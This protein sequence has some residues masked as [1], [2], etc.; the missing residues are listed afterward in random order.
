MFSI[1]LLPL[2]AYLVCCFVATGTGALEGWGYSGRTY[3]AFTW[4]IHKLFMP[5]RVGFPLGL[6]LGA[7][8]ALTGASGWVLV[9]QVAIVLLAWVQAFTFFHQ[10]GYFTVR[11]AIDPAQ[12]AWSWQ[13][14]SS[15]SSAKMEI[16]AKGRN[17]YLVASLVTLLAL[18]LLLLL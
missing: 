14:Q 8:F 2:L 12:P 5:N 15:T 9:G 11:H 16:G 4:N 13:T 17:R 1:I 3:E 18:G 6:I 10:L 7:L